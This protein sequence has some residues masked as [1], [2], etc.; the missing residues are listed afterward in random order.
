MNSGQVS[1]VGR[2]RCTFAH[3]CA[4]LS[5]P[6]CG[7]RN[8]ARYSPSSANAY[9]ARYKRITRSSPARS[10]AV[11]ADS[12]RGSPPQIAFA[13]RIKRRVPIHQVQ[14]VTL[15]AEQVR[16]VRLTVGD[17]PLF[18]WRQ[19]DESVVQLQELADACPILTCDGAR[20]WAV[21][22]AVPGCVGIG[23][24]HLQLPAT[25]QYEVLGPRQ[26]ARQRD[27]VQ[28]L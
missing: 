15:V 11:R 26:T 18:S 25:R 13:W 5:S 20:R 17:H 28:T 6:G 23:E 7:P 8:S 21:G 27:G 19:L 4:S 12:V 1:A 14:L 22:A 9:Q 3:D 2:N 24:H 10:Y 16:P